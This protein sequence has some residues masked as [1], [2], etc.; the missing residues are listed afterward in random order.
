MTVVS[1]I[2][3]QIIAKTIQAIGGMPTKIVTIGRLIIEAVT[4]SPANKPKSEPKKRDIKKPKKALFIVIKIS[5]ITF[6]SF[7]I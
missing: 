4:K 6:G 2:P 7:I 3:N 1:L 5:S